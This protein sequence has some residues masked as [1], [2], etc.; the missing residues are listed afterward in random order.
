MQ[1]MKK[2]ENLRLYSSAKHVRKH[3]NWHENDAS[4][5]DSRKKI[6]SIS[7]DFS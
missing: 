1:G 3:S 2:I 7:D 6:K 5:D 4:I